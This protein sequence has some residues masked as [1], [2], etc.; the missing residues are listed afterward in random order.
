M[1]SILSQHLIKGYD[2][3]LRRCLHSFLLLTFSTSSWS[4]S[5]ASHVIL[6]GKTNQASNTPIKMQVK[7]RVK[8]SLTSA[9]GASRWKM[10]EF[11]VHIFPFK[12]STHIHS[13]AVK[14]MLVQRGGRE[15][16]RHPCIAI[17]HWK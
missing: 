11:K 4:M 16:A 5:H 2:T 9:R 8:P 1:N 15:E 14:V 6:Q 13:P 12:K 10:C 7:I 17:H 3:H